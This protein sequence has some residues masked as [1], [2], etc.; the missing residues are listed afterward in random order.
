VFH[1]LR[2]AKYEGW[3]IQ[4][5][6]QDPRFFNPAIYAELGHAHLK[7]TAEAAGFAIAA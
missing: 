1:A 5:A 7:R 6:E 3:V 2:G 4:E